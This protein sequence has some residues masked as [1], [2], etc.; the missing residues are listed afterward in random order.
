MI[1]HGD[2][3][4]QYVDDYLHELLT[5]EDAAYVQSHVE[6]C[7][8]C[9]VA[10]DEAQRRT[11]LLR[12]LPAAEPSA[13]LIRKTLSRVTVASRRLS[14]RQIA[15]RSFGVAMAA[16]ILIVAALNLHYW[17]LSPSPFDLRVVAQ[18]Q[19]M[20][21]TEAAIRAVLMRHD[22][23]ATVPDAPVRIE[24]LDPTA[25][26][27][28]ELASFVTDN[29]GTGAPRFRLPD[30]NDGNYTLRITASP[31][32]DDQSINIPIT[33]HRTWKLML[34][35][36]KPVYQPGQTMHFRAL[37]LREPDLHPVAGRE[38]VF[39]ITDPK[40]NLIYKSTSVTSQFGI[41]STDCALATEILEGQ[42]LIACK[43]GDTENRQTVEVKRYVLPKFK[44]DV[45]P[46]K[47]YYQP[48][49]QMHV[50]IHAAYFFGK[51]VA[52]GVVEVD[53]HGVPGDDHQTLTTD[54]Q[55][56]AELQLHLPDTFAGLPQ[57]D[58]DAR[59]SLDVHVR[60]SAGQEQ[61]KTVDRIITASPLHIEIIPDS[62]ELTQGVA[63]TV[64]VLTTYPDGSPA[65]ARVA[66][67][68]ID[69]EVQTGALGVGY[70]SLTPQD[71]GITLTATASDNR[72]LT[73]TRTV[74][75][76]CGSPTTGDFAVRTDK[77]VYRDGESMTITALGGGIEPVFIDL[78]KDGQTLLTET[79]PMSG[80]HGQA[81]FDLPPD[82]FGTLKLDAYRMG[83]DAL[84]ARKSRILYVEPADQ[85]KLAIAQDKPEYRPGGDAKLNF[86]L[87]DTAGKPTPG[88]ISLAA[89]DESV[90]SVLEQRPGMEKT[91]F[92]LEQEMLKPIYAIYNWSPDQVPV[93]PGGERSELEQALFAH[94]S[95]QTPQAN[96]ENY[97][98]VQ[99]PTM[100]SGC[101]ASAAEL[102]SL[103]DGWLN[104]LENAWGVIAVILILGGIARLVDAGGQWRTLAIILIIATFVIVGYVLIQS[105][106]TRVLARWVSLSANMDDDANAPLPMARRLLNK[107]VAITSPFQFFDRRN[108]GQNVLYQK[109]PFL[110]ESGES[111]M[112]RVRQWFPETLL[113]RPELI[114][115]D[116]GHA[117]LDLDLADS[118]TNW[119][120]S[121]SAVDANGRLG[122]GK[123][124]IRV[125]Q[126]FFVD[127]NL[128]VALTRGDE[129]SLPVVVYSYSDR[130]QSVKVTLD[131]G[132]KWFTLLDTPSKHLD[133][134]AGEVASVWFRIRVTGMGFHDLQV[135]A[136]GSGL[137]GVADAEKR[138]I[139][140][141]A[142]G[143]VVEKTTNGSLDQPAN[144]SVTMPPDAVADSGKLIVKI[145]P[146]KFSEVVEGL[147]GI[148]QRP[149]GCFEQTS[150]TT[151][152]NVLALSYLR[153]TG[154]AVPDVEAKARE[155]I[156]LGYQ[157]LV[158][159][160]VPG[161]GFDWFGQP[162]ANPVLT[163]YG[164]ME[165]QDMSK[166]ANVDPAL[167]SRTR[168]WLLSQRKADGSWNTPQMR[169]DDGL[170]GSVLHGGGP[171][172]NLATTA[173]I[174]W[175]VFGAG[176]SVDVA[177]TLD[178]LRRQPI[179]QIND[180]YVL[181]VL[182]NALESIDPSSASPVLDR[183]AQLP[184]TS[185][186]G[187]QAWW[188][189]SAGQSTAFYGSGEAGS[190][191]TTAM[192]AL[193]LINGHRDG[194]LSRQALSWLVSKKD[195]TGTWS[196]TQATVLA[197]KALVAG[198][199]KPIGPQAARHIHLS[200]GD[201]Y[202]QDITIAPDQ[203]DVLQQID[204]SAHLRGGANNITLADTT[205]SDSGY[206]IAFSYHT[207]QYPAP[208]NEP[209][210]ISIDYDRTDLTV[211]QTITATATIV[212]HMPATA[213]MILLDLPL[214]AGFSTDATEFEN[215]V[216][217]GQIA[218]YQITPRSVIVY[219]RALA[220]DQP[221]SLQYRLTATMPVKIS[222]PA[223]SVYEYY[224]P[225]RRA[226][227]STT[228]MVVK[229]AV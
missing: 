40:G 87:T 134:K 131:T 144:V 124:D 109:T 69:H 46:D 22:T 28:V 182:A 15:W 34:S 229:A 196:S 101:D 227:S 18:Q 169:F 4:V 199:G 217:A 194:Q 189:Q 92:T 51:P 122:A 54:A 90:F 168:N 23:G 117:N 226:E 21:G 171:D 221:M 135:V 77:A 173:Y 129:I 198:S 29:A 147:D 30:L 127:M 170:G 157:R 209:L 5:D 55:G 9:Q 225:T 19:M 115:D 228:A 180:P 126:P 89:V 94:A 118:I 179:E 203:S 110:G 128:P 155:Y 88:A 185:A 205:G 38:A 136:R 11:A 212:N 106:R 125:F 25:V 207:P 56:K 82:V 105:T 220:P 141:V 72:G 211:G 138:T 152:P 202:A 111:P 148:F 133:L 163:A 59:I 50:A 32:G 120:L 206:Q 58:G 2:H 61:E 24:L 70:F 91:F 192:S 224:D 102:Q 204:L 153:A 145:Y 47:P 96:N 93:A 193:A 195:S 201:G 35:S 73:T 100:Q 165:F 200:L 65:S 42:Y 14:I 36:D 81:Q 166:V 95:A 139:E 86:S 187:K 44:I 97:G 48:G 1:S 210:G 114:T 149:Y 49:S 85:L 151:Y 57:D 41:T 208:A 99:L 62:G 31:G 76:A 156:N 215:M 213:P 130:P 175:A 154:K 177:P 172:P 184:Q 75:L 123:S 214:P 83:T 80:G 181:A 71:G 8:I 191:E 39:T 67:S 160:E 66:I 216:K 188:S 37:A 121:A 3:V 113:W 13:E 140:V 103:R 43:I 16:V 197:L 10:M 78:I 183:L 6:R 45:D 143:P 26:R 12:G 64:Y 52:N 142:T 107:E 60:D 104:W 162:A 219:L 174:A 137:G 116:A 17:F 218:K 68:G 53:L 222:V 84:A 74:T 27:P 33:L 178:Y 190:V 167:I 176:N 146:S 20:P 79:I 164:L 132:G 119:R 159:F 223:A 112:P 150:S 158:S 186:D 108:D 161:G 63:N 7:A 98:G